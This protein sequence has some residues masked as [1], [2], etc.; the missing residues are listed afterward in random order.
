MTPVPTV[1]A[2]PDPLLGVRKTV[3]VNSLSLQIVVLEKLRERHNIMTKNT[4]C[5]TLAKVI[6]LNLQPYIRLL[7]GSGSNMILSYC[8]S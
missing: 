6:I 2:W 7:L 5:H 1:G 8:I 4:L 3:V